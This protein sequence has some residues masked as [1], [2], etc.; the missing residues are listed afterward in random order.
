MTGRVVAGWGIVHGVDVAVGRDGD[1][2][3]GTEC[4]CAGDQPTHRP[5]RYREFGADVARG[6]AAS[7]ACSASGRCRASPRACGSATGL[8]VVRREMSHQGLA[9]SSDR[10]AIRRGDRAAAAISLHW[11][12]SH[13]DGHQLAFALPVDTGAGPAPSAP[14]RP[15]ALCGRSVTGNHYSVFKTHLCK[16]VPQGIEQ[17]PRSHKRFW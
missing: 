10:D 6:K 8:L 15:H 13:R 14:F 2:Q 1:R 11:L 9:A 4:R 16:L 3:P 17:V 7:G 12:W 5:R